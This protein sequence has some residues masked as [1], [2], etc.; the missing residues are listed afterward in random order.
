MG[1]DEPDLLAT[2]STVEGG[3]DSILATVGQDDEE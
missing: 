3:L 2:F 1:D